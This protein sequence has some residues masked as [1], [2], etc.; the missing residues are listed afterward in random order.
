MREKGKIFCLFL[1]FSKLGGI[2][3]Q[4]DHTYAIYRYI[5]ICVNCLTPISLEIKGIKN[6]LALHPKFKFKFKK[7]RR[8]KSCVKCKIFLGL[9]LL[10][11]WIFL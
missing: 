11:I 3:F 4:T 6:S 1:F 5:Y 8:N 2:H 9:L 7:K 10:H